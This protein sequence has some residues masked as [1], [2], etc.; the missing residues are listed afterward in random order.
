MHSLTHLFFFNAE[1]LINTQLGAQIEGS[2]FCH[3]FG[4]VLG[5]LHSHLHHLEPECQWYLS[6]KGLSIH[7]SPF[8]LN[9]YLVTS[10][11]SSSLIKVITK[12]CSSE[13]TRTHARAHTHTHTRTHTH[14]H[15]SWIIFP[16]SHLKHHSE[17][18]KIFGGFISGPVVM[19]VQW[20]HLKS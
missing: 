17:I 1:E 10:V 19:S 8:V 4:I 13:H 18:F 11:T 3:L 5:A 16:F 9:S 14:T 20:L 7:C 6:D 12:H 2:L 15:I